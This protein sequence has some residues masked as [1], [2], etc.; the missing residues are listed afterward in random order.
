M[1]LLLYL[2]AA[3]VTMGPPVREGAVEAGEGPAWDGKESLYFTGGGRISRRD[4]S[5]TV[6]V[7][8]EGAGGA[9][10]LLFDF[11]G[12]LVA[13]EGRNRRVVRFERDGSLTVLADNY[14]SKKFNSPNDLTM[15]SR[16]RIYFSD[17][18]YG[19]REGMEMDMEGVY[20]IDAPRRVTR[21][22]GKEVERANGVLVSRGDEFLYVADNNNSQGGARKLYRFA[23]RADGS[24]DAASRALLFDWKQG[25]GPDGLKIDREGRLFVAGGRT[26]PRPPDETAEFKGGIYVLSPEGKLLEFIPVPTDE[27]T[28]CAFG[29]ADLQTLFITAG[30]E[31]WRVPVSTPGFQRL[32]NSRSRS[33]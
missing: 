28:N 17:P 1:L 30:G 23:L 7:F 2:L 24:I 19:N 27:V 8:R 13:C 9:N 6:H 11:E 15:D 26:Q 31:L 5:G 10:G 20:R 29:G 4:P 32:R 18:R 16:G 25:R 3:A 14:E 33:Y 12:R 21:V 22:L